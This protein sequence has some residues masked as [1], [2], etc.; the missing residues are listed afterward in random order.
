MPTQTSLRLRLIAGLLVGGSMLSG[1]AG[2][3]DPTSPSFDMSEYRQMVER[4][5]GGQGSFEDPAPSVPEMT[6][7]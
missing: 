7:E 2:S 5:K 6:P 1:C 3:K 4:Q